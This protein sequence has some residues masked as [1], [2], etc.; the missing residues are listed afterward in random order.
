[1]DAEY[2]AAMEQTWNDFLTNIPTELCGAV[3]SAAERTT[4][5]TQVERFGSE[6]LGDAIQR[7]IQHRELPIADRR[8][9]KW[10]CWLSEGASFLED[11]KRAHTELLLR[12]A[13]SDTRVEVDSLIRTVN[14]AKEKGR[15]FLESE[16]SLGEADRDLANHIVRLQSPSER[17]RRELLRQ[18]I[19]LSTR[20]RA[21]NVCCNDAPVPDDYSPEEW[22]DELVGIREDIAT[23]RAQVNGRR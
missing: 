14:A 2:N 12:K 7:W 3:M 16:W 6:V 23:L 11:A 1:M 4:I 8:T 15:S 5:R 19:S 22:R 17:E 21:W 18:F 20:F 13:W 9:D 10:G